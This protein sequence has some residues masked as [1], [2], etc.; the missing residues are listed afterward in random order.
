LRLL[1][2]TSAKRATLTVLVVGTLAMAGTIAALAAGGPATPPRP[3]GPPAA[4][5]ERDGIRLELWVDRSEIRLGGRSLAHVRVTNGGTTS[6]Q[7]EANECPAG[8]APVNVAAQPGSLGRAWEGVARNF[9][10]LALAE[11]R[12]VDGHLYVM[13]RFRDFRFL[14]HT[15]PTACSAVSQPETLEPGQTLEA[16]LFWDAVPSG[17]L[18]PQPGPA[19]VAAAFSSSAG[20]V[21]A[22]VEIQ[23]GVGQ[24]PAAI[25]LVEYLDRALTSDKFVAWLE[26][27]PAES[28]VNSDIVFWP[29][30]QGEFPPLD[31]Y[32]DIN[33]PVIQIGLH[34]ET[35]DNFEFGAVILDRA[36]GLVL[37]TRFEP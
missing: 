23:L 31:A 27:R 29:D 19:V 36:T 20:E 33:V 37:G 24:L 22:E 7:R 17:A 8:P 5:G 26:E 28:W 11:A 32:R 3:S 25:G 9:K 13:G 14:N 2:G 16:T 30:A 34:R 15:A 12:V 18:S 10:G 1:Q 21:S 4:T 35:P 6:P